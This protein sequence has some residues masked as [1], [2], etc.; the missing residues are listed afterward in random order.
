M[1]TP[2]I[3]IPA[4]KVS[5]LS[6]WFLS[7]GP[8]SFSGAGSPKKED[9]AS[10][11]EISKKS[12]DESDEAVRHKKIEDDMGQDGFSVRSFLSLLESEKLAWDEANADL[13]RELNEKAMLEE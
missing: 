8:P 4:K 6:S 9:G 11:T 5:P 10:P 12:I 3:K 7:G 13:K 1:E 2:K